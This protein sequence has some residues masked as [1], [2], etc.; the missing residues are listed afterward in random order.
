MRP[1]AAGPS[2]VAL[3]L[4]HSG[5]SIRG[6]GRVREARLA[7]AL[8]SIENGL[9]TVF[10]DGRME[11][12]WKLRP[13]ARWHDGV[14]V[15]S[16]DLTFSLEVGRDREM[17]GFSTAAYALI[18]SV[19]APD[20]STLTVTWSQP[21]IDADAVLGEFQI[22]L[23][24]KH[25]LEDT[26]RADKSGLL[27][28]PYWNTDFV[29]AGPYR[30]RQWTPGIGLTVEANPDYALGR[31]PIDQID[32]KVISDPN[33]LAANLLAGAVDVA[34]N[35]E[36]ID[37]GVQLRDQWRDGHV[38]FNFGSDVWVALFPQMTDP[39]PGVIGDVRFRRAMMHAIN[40]TEITDTLAFGMSPV[41]HTYLSPN[42]PA[43][44]EIEASTARYDYD[45]RRASQ[46]LEELGFRKGADGQYR[47]E[48][49]ARLEV[50]IRAGPEDEHAKSAQAVADYWQ[51]LGIGV[52]YL[53][54]TPQQFQDQQYTGAFPGFMVLGG[55][56]DVT[57]LRNLYSTQARL[58]SNNFRVAGSG[59]RSRYVN[60]EFDALLNTYFAT[61]PV[62]P[63]RQALA[64][65]IH[66]MADQ[67]TVE[68]LFYNPRPSPVNN[69]LQGVREQW[70]APYITW[71]AHQ[72]DIRN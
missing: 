63:R 51:R 65:I 38:V 14:P 1:S 42:Q 29:G 11:T 58:P 62:A 28:L 50:E 25:L 19:R 49:N 41:A 45:P 20:S 18:E 52:D 32:V 70:V 30:L 68:G 44:A 17:A 55:P 59:N 3:Q 69:R 24:P 64:N 8:P 31:P 46:L 48:A 71:N 39:Q 2:L 21:F 67:V 35:L 9:W 34:S 66:H 4:V 5:L 26:Y 12:T 40:R 54:V 33:T 57:A 43:N 53:R 6:E 16:D 72:W 7:E 22:G 13:G 47:D 37:A 60:P 56:N 23:L 61:I 10:P 27:D 36:S 15:T